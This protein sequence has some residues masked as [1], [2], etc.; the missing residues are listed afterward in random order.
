M[1]EVDKDIKDAMRI[2][3]IA[4][5]VIIIILLI[6]VLYAIFRP[7]P[8]MPSIPQPTP[9]QKIMV[10]ATP[11]PTQTSTPTPE[12]NITPTAQPNITQPANITQT[13]VTQTATPAPQNFTMNV[14]ATAT[15][16]IIKYTWE[17]I[18]ANFSDTLKRITTTEKTHHYIE[19]LEI[20]GT[21][22]TNGEQFELRFTFEDSQGRETELVATFESNKWLVSIMPTNKGNGTVIVDIDCEAQKGH[23]QRLYPPGSAKRTTTVEVV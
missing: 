15:P 4:G 17:G 14:S 18:T 19:I 9:E 23:C 12:T 6:G 20:D 5:P 8:V 1:E 10:E 13:N 3:K 22:I 2:Y 7:Q 11:E 21:P 16:Q